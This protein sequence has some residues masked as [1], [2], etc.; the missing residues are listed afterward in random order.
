MVKIKLGKKVPD[1]T[2]VA[3]N[4]SLFTLSENMGKN[5]VIYFYPKR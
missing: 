5:I 4:D 2:A 1:F 3:T